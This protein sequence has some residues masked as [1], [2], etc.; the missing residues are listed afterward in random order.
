MA[1]TLLYIGLGLK[2]GLRTLI[3]VMD[4]YDQVLYTCVTA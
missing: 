1:V 2:L 4:L 3:P